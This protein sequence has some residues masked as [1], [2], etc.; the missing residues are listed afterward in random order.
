MIPAKISTM[1][2]TL[3]DV[4]TPQEQLDARSIARGL[5]TTY[6]W[7]GQTNELITVAE[8]SINVSLDVP[9]EYALSALFHDCAEAFIGD[10][11]APVKSL[12]AMAPLREMEDRILA[13]ASLRF[14][15][16]YSMVRGE[17]VKAAD[18][19]ALVTEA[20]LLLPNPLPVLDAFPDHAPDLKFSFHCYRPEEAE[21]AF[22]HRFK[23]LSE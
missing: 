21:V 14:G 5:A 3:I 15:F 20:A 18:R 17:V 2:G 11:P 9:R 7:S 13:A 8:H 16:S 6:R 1:H 12:D 19:R 10:I 4:P 23:E 22:L